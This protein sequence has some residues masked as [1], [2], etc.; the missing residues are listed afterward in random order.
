MT[1]PYKD[2]LIF[3]INHSACI[4]TRKVVNVGNDLINCLE[5][6]GILAKGIAHCDG[7]GDHRMTE[8]TPHIFQD[9]YKRAL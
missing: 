6:S 1:F 5:N 4:T 9:K 7:V 2:V 3:K 8:K